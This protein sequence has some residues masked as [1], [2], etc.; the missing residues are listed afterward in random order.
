MIR[1]R[2]VR[3][4]TLKIQKQFNS[5]K[6]EVTFVYCNEVAMLFAL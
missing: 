6:K 1:K 2:S 4:T 3:V 5:E